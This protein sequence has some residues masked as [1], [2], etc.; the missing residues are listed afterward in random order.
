MSGYGRTVELMLRIW[1][2][3]ALLREVWFVR[4]EK[5]QLLMRVLSLQNDL[6]MRYNSICATARGVYLCFL[7]L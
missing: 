2:L 3:A 1:R 4:R 6:L 5:D 7:E